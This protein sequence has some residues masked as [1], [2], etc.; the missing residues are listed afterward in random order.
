MKLEIIDTGHLADIVRIC[1]HAIVICDHQTRVQYLNQAACDLLQVQRATV[2]GALANEAFE[3]IEAAFA[4]DVSQLK[5]VLGNQSHEVTVESQLRFVG[6]GDARCSVLFLRDA[7]KKSQRELVLEQEATTDE[8]SGLA[9]RRGFQR[10]LEAHLPG[11]LSLAIID[12]DHFKAI[13]DSRGHVIGDELI[14]VVG[15]R[16]RKLFDD[17]C[18]VAARMGGDEFGVLC[19][20]ADGEVMLQKLEVL[21]EGLQKMQKACGATISIGAVISWVPGMDSRELLTQADRCLYEAKDLGRN[22]MRYVT[23]QE[24]V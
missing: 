24:P 6:E 2:V 22:R 13:N 11:K 4:G 18:I 19:H 23:C 3:G 8:L 14:E 9:N 7:N 5:L 17:F 12:I 10:K 15:S 20:S 21:Q 16:M 1:P